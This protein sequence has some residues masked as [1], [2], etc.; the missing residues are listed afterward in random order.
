MDEEQLDRALEDLMQ[1]DSDFFYEEDL[2]KRYISINILT[3]IK[4]Y[5]AF[6][7]EKDVVLMTKEL[8]TL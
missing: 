2:R 1:I 5:F 3:E 4:K 7:S 6:K 8:K